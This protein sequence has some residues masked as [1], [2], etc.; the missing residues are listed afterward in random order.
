MQDILHALKIPRALVLE[1]SFDRPN[2]K[3]EVL[4]KGK[5][6]LKQL[7]KLLKDKFHGM[8]GIIYCLSKSETVDVSTYLNADCK[9]KAVFYHAGLGSHQRVSVQKRWHSGEVN[10]VCATIAFGMGIDKPDVVSLLL[11]L[12]SCFLSLPSL[13]NFS[14]RDYH[15]SNHYHRQHCCCHQLILSPR[16]R[17]HLGHSLHCHFCTISASSS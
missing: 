2:L 16:K 6:P 9:V 14:S 1:T 13:F 12:S 17:C 15:H 8:C 5:D 3:Y 11:I 7:G 10:V 4:A